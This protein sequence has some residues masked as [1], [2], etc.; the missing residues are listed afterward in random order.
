MEN[1]SI[2][3]NIQERIVEKLEAA[4]AISF[5]TAITAAEANLDDDE[6][7]WLSYVAGGLFSKVKKTK[8][9]RYYTTN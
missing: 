6:K 4:K 9:K 3:N 1:L 5:E 7:S 2:V 8:D